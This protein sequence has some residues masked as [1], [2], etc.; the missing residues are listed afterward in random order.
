MQYSAYATYFND[1]CGLQR[2][3]AHVLSLTGV[4]G[5]GNPMFCGCAVQLRASLEQGKIKIVCTN[6]TTKAYCKLLLC[7]QNTGNAHV[8]GL[9]G[10]GGIGKTALATALFNDLAPS[11]S[12][13]ACFLLDV[14]G[15][16]G[17][18]KGSLVDRQTELLSTL[19]G[20]KQKLEDEDEGELTRILRG[21]SFIPA[22][23]IRQFIT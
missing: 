13:A 3:I 14:R 15:R 9:T 16:I 20:M 4:G 22:N 5:V 21:V 7:V 11:F 2:M 1:A 8:L 10:M 17:Q 18:P 12:G 19:S 23:T 6:N